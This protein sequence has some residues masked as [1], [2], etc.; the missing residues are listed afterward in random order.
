[1]EA[2]ETRLFGVRCELYNTRLTIFPPVWHAWRASLKLTTAEELKYPRAMY[3][4]RLPVVLELMHAEADVAP[5]DFQ[6]L[7]QDFPD[8]VTEFFTRKKA[9]LRAMIPPEN[10]SQDSPDALE[11]AT[12]VFRPPR[13]CDMSAYP[14]FGRDG[15]VIGWKQ[16]SMIHG[17]QD[18]YEASCYGWTVPVTHW[19]RFDPNLSKVAAF[20]VE[21]CGRDPLAT[22]A[23]D[24]DRLDMRFMCRECLNTV[25]RQRYGYR[26][27]L[28]GEIPHTRMLAKA[29]TWRAAVRDSSW[30]KSILF[31]YAILLQQ[32][33]HYNSHYGLDRERPFRL[34][35]EPRYL[36]D[37]KEAEAD[38]RPRILAELPAWY[39]NRCLGPNG[40]ESVTRAD[41]F[42][43]L[44][45]ECVQG[46]DYVYTQR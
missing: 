26:V 27:D 11:L 6:T 33:Y 7:V 18:D 13:D 39:C 29:Y 21:L 35:D 46:L 38:A 2:G 43:H 28:N 37:A 14:E 41:V 32:L 25:L 3:I 16:H 17:Y 36:E 8:M 10:V 5:E 20:L 40:G 23:E 34:L 15:V 45:Q 12:S 44:V 4:S 9:E 19:G 30:H 1:M 31:T 42:R 22:T 24:M